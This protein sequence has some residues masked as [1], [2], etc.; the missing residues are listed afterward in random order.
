[1]RATLYFIQK[2]LRWVR[3]DKLEEVARYLVDSR[4]DMSFDSA[5]DSIDKCNDIN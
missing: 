1:M 3:R 2:Y 4:S 5:R